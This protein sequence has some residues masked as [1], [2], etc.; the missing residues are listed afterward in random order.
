MTAAVLGGAYLLAGLLGVSN[1]V[2]PDWTGTWF[3]LSD[4]M[5]SLI[6]VLVGAIML[7]SFG[8]SREG[9]EEDADSF[10]LVGSLMGLFICGVSLLGLLSHSLDFYVI[11]NE[12]LAG[13]SALQD[14]SPSIALG[15]PS[16]LVLRWK[17]RELKAPNGGSARREASDH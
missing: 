6:L 4:I 2:V 16:A 12:D 11:H 10:L 8:Q 17:W 5:T 14:L 3:G 9:R 7:T 1:L 13:W 15:L